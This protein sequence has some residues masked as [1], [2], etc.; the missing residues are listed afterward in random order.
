MTI[1]AA[2]LTG[3]PYVQ[4]GWDLPIDRILHTDTPHHY[5]EAKKGESQEAFADRLAGNLD[6]LIVRHGPKPLPPS[7]P[8]R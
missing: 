3:L 6:D 1:A 7:S 2:S 5:R 4:D 8:S